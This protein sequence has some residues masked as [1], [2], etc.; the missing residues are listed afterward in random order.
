MLIFEIRLQFFKVFKDIFKFLES[1]YLAT[2]EEV[3]I[4]QLISSCLPLWDDAS[5]LPQP[6]HSI[7][8]VPL[9]WLATRYEVLN[10]IF[11]DPGKVE[12]VVPIYMKRELVLMEVNR[13]I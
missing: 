5:F 11:W 12:Y 3:A 13:L 8:W 9:S 7:S 2:D 4:Q 6:I 1:E 10:W